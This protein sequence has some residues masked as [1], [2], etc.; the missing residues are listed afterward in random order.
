MP[1]KV[2]LILMILACGFT[3]RVAWAYLEFGDDSKEISA[4]N[5]ASAEV[6]QVELA[7][8]DTSDGSDITVNEEDSQSAGSEDD[9]ADDGQYGDGSQDQYDDEKG[10]SGD[11]LEAGGSPVS[12][13]GPVPLMPDGQCPVEFPNERPD[14]CYSGSAL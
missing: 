14:G 5:A 2:A 8:A 10:N 7:Q 6:A 9:S 1:M 12:R 4:A 13:D 3:G 11:L